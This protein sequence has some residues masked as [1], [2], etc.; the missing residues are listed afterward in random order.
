[1]QPILVERVSLD[2]KLGMGRIVAELPSVKSIWA[3]LS[4]WV[5][6]MSPGLTADFCDRMRATQCETV[7]AA[8]ANA[9]PL[10]Y[11]CTKIADSLQRN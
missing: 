11:A 5:V 2:F 4:R 6:R 1:L 9:E 10:N 8:A 7:P 3:Q